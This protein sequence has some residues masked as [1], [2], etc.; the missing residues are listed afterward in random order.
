[1]AREK[2]L[3]RVVKSR[4]ILALVA[5]A[6]LNV[7]FAATA[8]LSFDHYL[9]AIHGPAW[10][11]VSRLRRANKNFEVAFFGSSLV[12]YALNGADANFLGRTVDET[13]HHWS[14]FTD[15]AL[16]TISGG[17]FRTFDFAFGGQIPSD[18]CL[19]LKEALALGCHPQVALYGIGPRDFLDP[20]AEDPT[21]TDCYKYLE[22]LVDTS[23]VDRALELPKVTSWRRSLLNAVYLNR[24]AVDIQQ[25]LEAALTKTEEQ[26]LSALPDRGLQGFCERKEL[27]PT[28]KMGD[29]FPGV[30]LI[31]PLPPEVAQRGYRELFIYEKV[32][33]H[34]SRRIEAMQMRGLA[35]FIDICKANGINCVLLNMPLSPGNVELYGKERYARFIQSLN[36]LAESRGAGF[37]DLAHEGTWE[38]E[39]FV[40]SVHLNPVGGTK[41][42]QI[43]APKL[44]HYT[45]VAVARTDSTLPK[46]PVSE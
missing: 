42:V 32:Y 26:C 46:Y 34:D 33:R 2:I 15:H 39:L 24:H 19:M 20:G 23:D 38:K 14:I 10:W 12:V 43:L 21:S 13:Q 16:S 41:V 36:E 9:S 5:F 25:S 1:L 37:V 27:L 17:R 44:P 29:R 35:Q 18:A 6:I 22:R 31:D 28:Y 30:Y 45:N 4:F 3:Q 40:D 8:V 7:Y 11:V